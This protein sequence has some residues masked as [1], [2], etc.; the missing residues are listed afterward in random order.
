MAHKLEAHI[1][2]PLHRRAPVSLSLRLYTRRAA[3]QRGIQVQLRTLERGL[4][5]PQRSHSLR[6]R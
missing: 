6:S 2:P 4:D 3:Q 1:K 5:L